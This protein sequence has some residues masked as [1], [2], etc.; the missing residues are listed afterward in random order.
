MGLEGFGACMHF[1]GSRACGFRVIEFRGLED[2]GAVVKQSYQ[3]V[4]V[5]ILNLHF[6]IDRMTNNK[7]A[8]MI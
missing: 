6:V 8:F 2:L 7:T 5:K 1:T 4:H 3:V